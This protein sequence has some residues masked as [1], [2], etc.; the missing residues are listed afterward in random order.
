M[1]KTSIGL[2][3]T[4]RANG[5]VERKNE[6]LGIDRPCTPHKVETNFMIV[7]PE[8]VELEP[9]HIRRGFRYLLDGG[10]AGNAQ[11]IGH[12]RA[13]GCLCHQKVCA[14][15]YHRRTTHGR[16]SDRR[17]IVP[18]EQLRINRRQVGHDSVARR[19]FDSL[20]GRP[21]VRDADIISRAR[22][23]IFEREKRDVPRRVA[24]Q[25]GGGRKLPVV[26]LKVR[27]LVD[28]SDRRFL[29]RHVMHREFPSLPT[30]L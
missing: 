28:R 26:L 21:I 19:D 17:S 14:G 27:V 2:A 15:P 30:A 8:P 16:N 29:C 24:P 1:G 12:T 13:L 23:A 5:N 7:V 9:E 10:A 20:E 4:C 3:R 22:I 6:D 25:P 11:R 18:P